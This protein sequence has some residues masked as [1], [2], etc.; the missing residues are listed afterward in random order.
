VRT[1]VSSVNGGSTYPA[2]RAIDGNL[3]TS[4]FTQPPDAS[5]FYELIL[6]G[7]ATLTELRMFGNREFANGFDFLRVPTDYRVWTSGFEY[8]RPDETVF[9]SLDGYLA[10]CRAR[11]LR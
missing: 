6:P 4:W 3:N 2:D 8:R 9:E 10:A 1:N 7:D 11:G 5:P